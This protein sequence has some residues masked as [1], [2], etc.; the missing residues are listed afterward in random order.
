MRQKRAKAYRKQMAYYKYNFKFREPYQVL[1]DDE[2]VL[3]SSRIKLNLAGALERTI[4]APV[5]PMI[6]QCCMEALYRSKNE[7]AISL[8]KR[9]ER[10]RCGHRDATQE[11]KGA[12]KP[13]DCLWDVVVVEGQNKH[14]YVVATQKDKLRQRLRRVPA[15]PLLY[16]NRSVMI[17]E[18]MSSVTE[19][20]RELIERGK[21]VGGLNEVATANNK[22]RKKSED[23]SGSESESDNDDEKEGSEA[24]ADKPKVKK[25]KG[26]KQP[27]PLSIKKKKKPVVAASDKTVNDTK[28]EGDATTGKKRRRRHHGSTK[29]SDEGD[30][31]NSKPQSD[32]DIAAGNEEKGEDAGEHVSRKEVKQAQADA[33]LAKGEEASGPVEPEE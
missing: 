26:P 7:D 4:Q 23:D 29:N 24:E 32:S 9:F 5:K 12:K 13:H 16:V 2:I 15:V 18:P 10:R 30:N 11:D 3:E 28:P 14:R 21:L 6:T 20:A 8:A 22:K 33:A 1:V 31:S 17:M 27:N 25:R 19:R